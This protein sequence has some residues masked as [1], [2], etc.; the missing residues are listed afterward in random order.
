MVT[1]MSRVSHYQDLPNNA[2]ACVAQGQVVGGDGC[3]PAGTKSD[4]SEQKNGF[5]ATAR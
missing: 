4:K 5:R 1:G 2:A 3:V